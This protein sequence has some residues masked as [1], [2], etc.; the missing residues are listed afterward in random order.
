MS[1]WDLKN[2]KDAQG[3]MLNCALLKTADISDVFDETRK[4]R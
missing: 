4:P 1:D 3:M 2:V